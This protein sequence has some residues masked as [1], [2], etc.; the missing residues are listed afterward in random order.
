V[1]KCGLANRLESSATPAG[2]RCHRQAGLG[3]KPCTHG[4]IARVRHG[5][6]TTVMETTGTSRCR[7]MSRLTIDGSSGR[8]GAYRC[9]CG[10]QTYRDQTP[11]TAPSRILIRSGPKVM[12]PPADSPDRGGMRKISQRLTG[13]QHADRRPGP[14]SPLSHPLWFDLGLQPS[15]CR[16]AVEP[17]RCRHSRPKCPEF[18]RSPIS[19]FRSN[20]L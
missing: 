3:P 16:S 8:G 6:R 18:N 9:R 10:C 11:V 19:A 14:P 12:G 2:R 13:E 20:L 4:T 1:T 5:R 15:H 17:E 7:A